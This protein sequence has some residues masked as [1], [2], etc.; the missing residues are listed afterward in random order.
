MLYRAC[1]GRVQRGLSESLT[2]SG[3]QGEFRSAGPGACGDGGFREG[4]CPGQPTTK[5]TPPTWVSHDSDDSG[6]PRMGQLL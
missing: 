3:G 4:R 5:L 2:A 6:Y 1:P